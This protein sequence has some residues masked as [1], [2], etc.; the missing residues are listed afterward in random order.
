[1]NISNRDIFDGSITQ[2]ATNILRLFADPKKDVNNIW[3]LN[4]WI[5]I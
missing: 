4:V 2:Q 5:I 3:S 1:M